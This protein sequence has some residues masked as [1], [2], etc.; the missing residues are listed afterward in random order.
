MAVLIESLTATHPR[1]L[2]EGREISFEEQPED[3]L[4]HELGHAKPYT[5]YPKPSTLSPKPYKHQPGLLLV[6]H[7]HKLVG[8]SEARNPKKPKQ[9]RYPQGRAFCAFF[10]VFDVVGYRNSS[11]RKP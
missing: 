1:I 5:L 9:E 7:S 4:S 11:N 8:K 6:V 3:V 2:P 10:D